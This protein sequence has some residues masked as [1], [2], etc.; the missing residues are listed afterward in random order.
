MDGIRAIHGIEA[1]SAPVTDMTSIGIRE[2]GVPAGLK[3]SITAGGDG[4]AET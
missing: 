1:S 2:R 3:S 4:C